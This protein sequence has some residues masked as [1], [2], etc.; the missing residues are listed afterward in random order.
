MFGITGD[1]TVIVLLTLVVSVLLGRLQIHLRK[2][3]LAKYVDKLLQPPSGKG[4][5]PIPVTVITGFLGAGKTTLLNR[6]LSNTSGLKLFV[7]ENEA[8]SIS[9]DHTLL[10]GDATKELKVF[11]NGCMCCTATGSGSDLERTLARLAEASD[12]GHPVHGVVIELSGLADPGPIVQ[13]FFGTQLRQRYY[14]DSVIAVVDAKHIGAHMTAGRIFSQSTEARRQIAYADLVLLNKTDIA[15]PAQCSEAKV[16][17]ESV[18]PGVSVLPCVQAGVPLSQLLNTHRFDRAAQHIKINTPQLATPHV[19]SAIRA[20]TIAQ[21]DVTPVDLRELQ[22]CLSALLLAYSQTL[23]RVK[24]LLWVFPTPHR[25]PPEPQLFVVQGV[26]AEL[27][28]HL[29]PTG[30]GDA[31]AGAKTV[32]SHKGG[33]AHENRHPHPRDEHAAHETG[34]VFIG[35]GLDEADIRRRFQS[36]FSSVSSGEPRNVAPNAR[37]RPARTRSKS[38]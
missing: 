17:I 23:Y 9:I 5:P 38:R 22:D 2:R 30:T 12:S 21:P 19:H 3:Q 16:A 6:L 36:V 8:G 18:N 31:R 33:H 20:I 11:K 28:G 1:I 26:H 14:V 7:V 10:K 25:Q 4:A 24:G 37:G 35:K 34:I 13:T 29:V 15:S 32:G 27:H